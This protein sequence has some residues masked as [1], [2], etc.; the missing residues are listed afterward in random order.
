[1]NLAVPKPTIVAGPSIWN[2][3]GY[4]P[5]AWQAEHLHNRT[6]R[7][8]TLACGRRSGKSSGFV[9]DAWDE[10]VKPPVYIGGTTHYPLIY[11]LA[12]SYEL[13]QKIW[14]PFV[15][16]CMLP[17]IRPLVKNYDKDRKLIDF[18]DP[19]NPNEKQAGPRIQA[20]TTENP[21]S[22]AGD[23]VTAG[24]A[25]EAHAITDAAMDEF[26]PALL[27]SDGVL[28]S[29]GIPQSDNWFRVHWEVG[30]LTENHEGR[31][32]DF[33]SASVPSI[34]NPVVR[35]EVIER[36]RQTLPERVFKQ[37]Y[38]ALWSE[39]EG[40]VFRNINANFRGDGLRQPTYDGYGKIH[41]GP[42][43]MAVDPARRHDYTVTYVM[44]ART[45]EIVDSYRVNQLDYRIVGPQI[46]GMYR[47]WQ[48]VQVKVDTSEGG[49]DT[50]ADILTDEGCLVDR[51]IFTK[52]TKGP[53]VQGLVAAM[54]HT[55]L[56]LPLSDEQLRKELQLYG[57]SITA[58]GTVT[59]SAPAGFF[60]DCVIALG[61]LVTMLPTYGTPV[62]STSQWSFG[63]R[64][65]DDSEWGRRTA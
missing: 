62:V 14:E 9:G 37:R 15:A 28:R 2:V 57:S 44:N 34:A 40:K 36:Y 30:Q 47:R 26:L 49:G 42:Y 16:T 3:I 63:D 39:A 58:A 60:D 19:R 20:K 59:Y 25:D 27:D 11:I 46:A 6:E 48:C 7:T 41:G 18:Y 53:L 21:I 23:R 24:Y 22:L 64:F 54:E 38:L 31:G 52:A 10:L 13:T 29:A 17:G 12:P 65:G 5:L 61:M 50:L 55:T 8:I 56:R 35:P 33:Y 51:F 43:I 1:M 45:R 32:V 4:R